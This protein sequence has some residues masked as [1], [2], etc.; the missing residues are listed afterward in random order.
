MLVAFPH[1]RAQ[2]FAQICWILLLHMKK[3]Q[4]INFHSTCS[5]AGTVELAMWANTIEKG[6]TVIGSDWLVS[7]GSKGGTLPDEFTESMFPFRSTVW[8]CKSPFRAVKWYSS[9]VLTSILEPPDIAENFV[10]FCCCV[11]KVPLLVTFSVE[12]WTLTVVFPRLINSNV[13]PFCN[14]NNRLR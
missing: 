3:E 4:V 10:W 12:T 5:Q 1:H 9:L 11:T 6:A 8:L 7:I 13:I 2:T 14:G